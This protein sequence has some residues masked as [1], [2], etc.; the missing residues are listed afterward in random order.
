MQQLGQVAAD[1]PDLA[2]SIHL[3]CSQAGLPPPPSPVASGT[4]LTSSRVSSAGASRSQAS[5]ASSRSSRSSPSVRSVPSRTVVLT[6][7]A[8]MGTAG[9]PTGM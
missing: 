6:D 8:V 1:V 3:V 9:T 7:L 5:L 4:R 2:P